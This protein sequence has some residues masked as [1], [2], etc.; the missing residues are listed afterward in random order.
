MEKFNKGDIV[1]L[2]C[3][4]CDRDCSIRKYYKSH[5]VI[6]LMWDYYRYRRKELIP[7]I[8]ACRNKG[9]LCSYSKGKKVEFILKHEN[10]KYPILEDLI[11]KLNKDDDPLYIKSSIY[12]MHICNHPEIRYSKFKIN[13]ISETVNIFKGLY[14]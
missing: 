13:T 6:G 1:T 5:Q 7:L 10:E 11:Y 12:D 4:L 8:P 14:E 2:D 9:Y 3:R